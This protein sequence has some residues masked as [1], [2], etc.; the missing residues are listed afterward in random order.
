MRTDKGNEAQERPRTSPKRPRNGSAK[1]PVEHAHGEHS[2][3]RSNSLLY[4]PLKSRVA[5]SIFL[6]DLDSAKCSATSTGTT[7]HGNPRLS[8]TGICC[9]PIHTV[10]CCCF[11]RSPQLLLSSDQGQCTSGNKNHSHTWSQLEAIQDNIDTGT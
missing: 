8:A 3:V 6:I 4:D 7:V 2:E 11:S 9:I 1:C 10:F 5:L